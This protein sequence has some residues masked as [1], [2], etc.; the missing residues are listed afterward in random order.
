MWTYQQSTGKLTD[1][2]GVLLATGYSGFGE[3][4]DNGAMQAIHDVGPIPQGIWSIGAPYTDPEKGALV[5]ALTPSATTE[6]FGRS[7]FLIHGDSIHNPG[8]ASKG[9]VILSHAT[10]LAISES[11]DTIL[12]VI[13]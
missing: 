3:G 4:K 11:D 12:Q 8:Q 10:R 1:V 5:M 2:D 13:P 7:A 6:T 9:C